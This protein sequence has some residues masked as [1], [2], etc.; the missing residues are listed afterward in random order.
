MLHLTMG[1]FDLFCR[2]TEIAYPQA[3]AERRVYNPDE[4][5]RPSSERLHTIYVACATLA[6]ACALVAIAV[7]VC[8]CRLGRP[9]SS[10]QL[11]ADCEQLKDADGAAG[12]L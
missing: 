9:S 3:I 2:P 6:G 12:H 8:Q 1:F 7:T 10:D 5:R 4:S 11:T